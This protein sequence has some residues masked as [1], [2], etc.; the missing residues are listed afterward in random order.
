MGNQFSGKTSHWS[1]NW[2]C[3][4]VAP[5]MWCPP[6][7]DSQALLMGNLKIWADCHSYYPGSCILCSH[8]ASCKG[9]PPLTT[10]LKLK[11]NM[12]ELFVGL[13]SCAR[14][15]GLQFTSEEEGVEF[16]RLPKHRAILLM[17]FLICIILSQPVLQ[18]TGDMCIPTTV[19]VLWFLISFFSTAVLRFLPWSR[20]IVN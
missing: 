1:D 18:S 11:G 15:T 14:K 3:R 7:P 6:H 12:M 8:T 2:S 13:W 5:E 20:I 17:K 16:P 9:R 19:F 4:N 10:E